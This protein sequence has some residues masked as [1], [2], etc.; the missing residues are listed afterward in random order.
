MARFNTRKVNRG[1]TS[2]RRR[3][4]DIT[5]KWSEN[6]FTG[7]SYVILSTKISNVTA[8]ETSAPTGVMPGIINSTAAA[9]S[10]TPVKISYAVEEP[11]F[12]QSTAMSEK[13]PY[14]SSKRLGGG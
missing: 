9:S 10:A 11:I 8:M 6:S 13:C 3:I 14:G 12:D 1:L 7:T 5:S 4:V 2:G